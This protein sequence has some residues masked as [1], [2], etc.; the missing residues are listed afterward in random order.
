MIEIKITAETVKDAQAEMAALLAGQLKT[1]VADQVEKGNLSLQGALG[2]LDSAEEKQG[3]PYRA[4]EKEVQALNPTTRK[5]KVKKPAEEPKEEAK[6]VQMETSASPEVFEAKT[7]ILND[8]TK[9]PAPSNSTVV[10]PFAVPVPAQTQPATPAVQAPPA[11]PYVRPEK[12][13]I[14]DIQHCVARNNSPTKRADTRNVLNKYKNKDGGEVQV[15]SDVQEKDFEAVY[16]DLE[17]LIK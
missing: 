3:E 17:A 5:K 6:V 1:Q 11:I 2:I 9:A 13:T 15:P 10:D 8:P 7:D 12:L 14:Q 16:S 4:I